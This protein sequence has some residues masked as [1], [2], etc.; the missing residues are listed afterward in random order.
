MCCKQND[1]CFAHRMHY[2]QI[3]ATDENEIIITTK[4]NNL[5]IRQVK[6]GPI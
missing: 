6:L 5:T 4:Q 3:A 1:S 2:Q